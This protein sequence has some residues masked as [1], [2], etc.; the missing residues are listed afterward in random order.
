VILRGCATIF[1]KS[2]GAAAALV[3][4]LRRAAS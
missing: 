1:V 4:L 2:A 3:P